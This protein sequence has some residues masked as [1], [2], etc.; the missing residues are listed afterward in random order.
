MGGEGG[1]AVALLRF[2]FL[3]LSLSP[4]VGLHECA[5]REKTFISYS[6]NEYET[7][8]DRYIFLACTMNSMTMA[9]YKPG[10]L[11]PWCNIPTQVQVSRKKFSLDGEQ[12]AVFGPSRRSGKG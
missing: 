10:A 6:R 7:D 9:S 12:G 8:I 11:S 5:S 1:K 4:S 3:V 2:S